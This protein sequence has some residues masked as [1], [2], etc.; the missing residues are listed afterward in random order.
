VRNRTASWMLSGLIGMTGSALVVGG[1]APQSK[2]TPI[3]SADTT[4]PRIE[5]EPMKPIVE[6]P[7]EP[8][9]P[10]E[11]GFDDVPLV[12]QEI[13]EERAFVD[14]YTRVNRPQLVV[15]VNRTL[16]GDIIP[17]NDAG[18]VASVEYSRQATSGVS[19]E[20][21]TTESTP[22]RDKDTIDR[23]ENKG[24]GAGK[25]T[26]RSDVYL[27]PGQYDEVQAKAID[28]VAIENT[29]ADWLRARGQVRQVAPMLARQKLTDQQIKDLQDGK[30]QVLAEVAEQLSADVLVHVTARP[31]RQTQQGLEVRII[32]EAMNTKGGQSLA[33]AFVDVPSPL[34]KTQ[35]NKYTRFLARKL[36]DG[37]TGTWDAG[38]PVVMPAPNAPPNQ[39]APN[40]ASAPQN[41]APPPNMPPAQP[42]APAPVPPPNKPVTAPTTP[43]EPMPK[44]AT[45]PTGDVMP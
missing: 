9:A 6:T 28:Y 15:F 24:S 11:P 36:M 16:E 14:A 25:Y 33:S 45:G 19:V 3:P 26:E 4:G 20:Q 29:L 27:K 40:D 32:A 17:V 30:P 8:T 43:A 2:R 12:N 13:P 42:E 21:R 1:C 7:P 22:Y 5:R 41:V 23:F 35:I 10:M 38:G 39:P 37:M 18:P 44:P 34:V 31:T